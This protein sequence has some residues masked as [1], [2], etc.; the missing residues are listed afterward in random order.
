LIDYALIAQA[1]KRAHD[2][3]NSGWFVFFPFYIF[4]I[5]FKKGEDKKNQYGSTTKSSL[6]SNLFSFKIDF[7]H[8]ISWVSLSGVVISTGSL[9]LVLSVFNGFEDLILKMYN[10]FDPHIKIISAQGKTFDANAIVLNDT[11]IEEQAYVLEEKALLKYQ[12]KEFIANVKGVS[13]SYQNIVIFDSLLVEGNYIDGYDNNNVAVIGSGVAYYLSMGLGAI[14]DQLQVF[15][16][17]RLNKTLL[18]AKSAFKQASVL[19]VG[20][21]SIQ[22]EIDEQYIITPL[23]FIQNLSNRP[24]EVSAIE[25]KLKDIDDMLRVQEKLKLKLG[26]DFIVKNRL[27]QQEFLYKILNTEKVAVF[28]ILVFIIIIAAFN[29]IGALSML[30][31][32]KKQDVKTLKSFGVTK[33]QAI[34]IFFNKS[35]LTI[36]T[37]ITIGVFIGLTLSFLQQTYG[38]VSM[39]SGAFVVDAYP[40][41]INLKDVFVVGITVLIVGLLASWYPSKVIINKLY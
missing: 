25:L 17:N 11:E 8:I 35:M 21:F 37:G 14:F 40:V 1:V 10:S 7:V 41:S 26:G 18:N 4:W 38:F 30:I 34:N 9:I 2:I 33:H 39:G 22:S 36:I 15:V 13:P 23:L 16:P 27:E 3:G 6:A 28:L 5:L 19:P 29:I 12:D 31:L 32:D 24:G 20:I